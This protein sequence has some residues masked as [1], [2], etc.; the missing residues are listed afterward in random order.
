MPVALRVSETTSLSSCKSMHTTYTRNSTRRLDRTCHFAASLPLLHHVSKL[1][2]AL[3]G[4][5]IALRFPGLRKNLLNLLLVVVT[6][7]KGEELLLVGNVAGVAGPCA[8]DEIPS[9]RVTMSSSI[10]RHDTVA[11]NSCKRRHAPH[12]GDA[13]NEVALRYV[14]RA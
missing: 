4:V 8:I 3:P 6:Q 9:R 10:H 1:A 14:D 12:G 5:A 2:A 11:I 7:L 13:H